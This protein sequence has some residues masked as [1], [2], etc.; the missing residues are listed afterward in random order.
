M[1]SNNIPNTFGIPATADRYL[2]VSDEAELRS[3]LADPVLTEKPF[4]ILGGGSNMVFSRHFSGTILHLENKGIRLLETQSDN[5]LVEA[6]AGEVWDDFVHH[7]IANGWHDVE[8]LVAIPGTVGAAPVQNVGAYGVEAKDVIY[9]VRTFEVGTGVERIFRNDECHFAYR[10]SIFKHE[11]LGRYVVWSVTFR[12]HKSFQPN[13]RYQA[14][15]DALATA[16]ITTPS[17]QQ[18]AD[19]IA[20]VRWSKLPRPEV[21]GSAGSFFKN[22]VV[23]VEHYQRLKADHPDIVAYSVPD[24]YKLAAGWLIE[25]AGWKGRSLGRCGVYAKQALVLVNL[26]GCTGAE[27]Q[28]LADAVTSDIQAQ[29]GV[30]LEKEAIII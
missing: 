23:S 29:F 16:G 6:A 4:L 7:C 20:E 25:H 19:T 28:A 24:G 15:T 14:I 22:P 26:G 13:I 11:L 17:P 18:L 30:T 9:S 12:L 5:I 27:V 3:L 8:N 2:V 1:S 21:M 10:D